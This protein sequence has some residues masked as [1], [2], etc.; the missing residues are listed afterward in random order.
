MPLDPEGPKA[1]LWLAYSGLAYAERPPEGALYEPSV[2]LAGKALKALLVARGEPFPKTQG[3]TLLL[4]PATQ[5]EGQPPPEILQVAV[6]EAHPL[7][8]PH[9]LGL[10]EIPQREGEGAL[11]LARGGVEGLLHG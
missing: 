11:E 8:G 3:L 7:R 10:P 1:W 2:F 9:P 5:A 6:L 4:G